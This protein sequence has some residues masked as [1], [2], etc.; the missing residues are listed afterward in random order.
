MIVNLIIAINLKNIK[1]SFIQLTKVIC[2]PF[3]PRGL[4]YDTDE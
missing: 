1:R 2:E 3:I 4:L